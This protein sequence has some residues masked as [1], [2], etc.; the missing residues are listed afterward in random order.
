MPSRQSA[1]PRNAGALGGAQFV[2]GRHAVEHPDVV[3]LIVLVFVGVVQVERVGS[4]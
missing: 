2:V 3:D 1:V 4:K